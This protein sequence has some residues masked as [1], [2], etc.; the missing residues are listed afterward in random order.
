MKKLLII[1]ANWE[2]E[3]LLQ[4]AKEMGLYVIATNPYAEAEGFKYSNESLTKL[5]VNKGDMVCFEPHSEY[6]FTVDGEKMYRMYTRNI[7]M[8]I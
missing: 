5:G 3:P 1:G 2:Q 7:T 4:K 8:V 6:E